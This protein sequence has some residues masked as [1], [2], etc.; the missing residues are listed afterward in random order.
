MVSSPSNSGKTIPRPLRTQVLILTF[1]KGMKFPDIPLDA[2]HLCLVKTK[3]FY[4]IAYV[5]FSLFFG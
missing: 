1:P 2:F 5:G 4:E 3:A